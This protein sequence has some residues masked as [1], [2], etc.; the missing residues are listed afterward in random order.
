MDLQSV[1]ENDGILEIELSC[2][3]V[4]HVAGPV[5]LIMGRNDTPAFSV[6][7]V[8]KDLLIAPRTRAQSVGIRA[9]SSRAVNALAGCEPGQSV[10]LTL[11][12]RLQHP[13]VEV[14]GQRAST[15][16]PGLGAAWAMFFSADLLPPP[17]QL[18][19]TLI[20]LAALTL[21]LGVWAR[22]DLLTTVGLCGFAAVCLLA[23]PLL[24][25]PPLA[26]SHLLALLSGGL[27][28]RWWGRH[29]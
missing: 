3:R 6:D 27:L 26:T 20:W 12:G 16:S 18:I 25:V 2:G 8:G 23:P 22:L 14:D 1:L 19:G 17:L 28:G 9:P 13:L 5:L 10:A 11:Q 4:S 24:E 15:E 7:A 21:P 29:A